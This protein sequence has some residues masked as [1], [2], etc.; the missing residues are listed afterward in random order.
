M[1]N[2]HLFV[3]SLFWHDASLPE[4]YH[5]LPTPSL[6][7][8]LAKSL[9]TKEPAQGTESWLCNTFNIIKQ[10]NWPIA[11]ITLNAEPLLDI[12]VGTGY[13][14]RADPVHLRIEQNHILLADS[15][16][17]DI[18][19]KESQQLADILN[20]HFA[21]QE[22]EFLLLSHDR[23]YIR[24]L[25]A[26]DIKTSE[27]SQVTGKNI[28]NF[29]PSGGDS[30]FWHNIFNE[31]QMLL[32]DHPF[33]QARQARNELA[34]NSVWFWGG[35]TMPTS[36]ASNYQRIWCDDFLSR[37]IALA[38]NTQL[39][40]LPLDA[41]A[42]QYAAVPGNHL[43]VLDTL[44]RRA[45][46]NDAYGWREDLKRLEENWF[47]PLYDAVQEGKIN[48]LTLTTQN[49]N[50]TRNFTISRKDLWKFWCVTEPLSTYT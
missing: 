4:I 31:I 18:S 16:V 27:L 44:R 34:V 7:I 41:K 9:K 19:I 13:W 15:Q 24:L 39:E 36:I 17:L 12:S 38:S 40:K 22:L 30:I 26:P 45:Q 23:W 47:S 10:Q 46:Y 48:K 3:P 33:N 1:T 29:L 5:E 42:W 8:L 43:I 11:P 2:L 50:S 20:Q 6:Q 37:A 49:V 21:K 32:H 14:L 25:K 35:G 28:N